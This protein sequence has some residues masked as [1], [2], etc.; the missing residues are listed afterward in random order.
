MYLY[1]GATQ[2]KI[3]SNESPIG[4]TDITLHDLLVNMRSDPYA[5]RAE[6]PEGVPAYTSTEENK[7]LKV[8]SDGDGGYETSWETISGGTTYTAGEG[9]DITSGAISVDK[10][11]VF[12]YGTM[13]SDY[14]D[15]GFDIAGMRYARTNSY[16]YNG[17]SQLDTTV[18]KSTTD[19]Y[20]VITCTDQ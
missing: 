9:I 17:S 15:N 16:S 14:G 18:A 4:T 10:S 8:V 6:L 2:T 5:R 12:N 1:L 7:Y 13:L 3:Q 19:N 11:A 20:W